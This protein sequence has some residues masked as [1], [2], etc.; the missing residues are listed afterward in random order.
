MPVDL[1]DTWNLCF[2]QELWPPLVF[3]LLLKPGRGLLF[4]VGVSWKPPPWEKC[5]QSE[6]W[7][8]NLRNVGS[9]MGG[10]LCHFF[11]FSGCFQ[12][13]FWHSVWWFGFSS[14]E[15]MEI[16]MCWQ[17]FQVSAGLP[18]LLSCGLCGLLRKHSCICA[19]AAGKQRESESGFLSCWKSWAL[20]GRV[21]WKSKLLFS[22][23]HWLAFLCLFSKETPRKTKK[24]IKP[25]KNPKQKIPQQKPLSFQFRKIGLLYFFFLYDGNSVVETQI[26]ASE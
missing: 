6:T 14:L 19:G 9:W 20:T 1:G 22:G 18:Q 8:E 25:H 17:L 4:T 13:S 5:K 26:C 21:G 10:H 23:K 12:V 2:C 24:K 7:L 15:L 3:S 11:I 16:R